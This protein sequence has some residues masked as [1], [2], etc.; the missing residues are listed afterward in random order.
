MNTTDRPVPNET[1]SDALARE[2]MGVDLMISAVRIVDAWEDS[3]A[4]SVDLIYDLWRLYGLG[5]R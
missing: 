1:N 4:N 3:D 5:N 2:A